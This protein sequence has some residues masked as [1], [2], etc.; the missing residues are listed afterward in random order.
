MALVVL[1]S[2][3]LLSIAP[4]STHLKYGQEKKYMPNEFK[5]IKFGMNYSKLSSMRGQLKDMSKKGEDFRKVYAEEINEGGISTVVYY[6]TTR[7]GERLYE[8]IINY[9]NEE[10]M[11]SEADKLLGSPNYKSSEWKLDI[12]ESYPL[13][14]WTYKNKIIYAAPLSGSEWEDG[15]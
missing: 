8:V 14:A 15:I 6:F 11:Q 12:K 7:G 10:I 5:K 13:H 9:D 1:L 3:T 2:C 4:S